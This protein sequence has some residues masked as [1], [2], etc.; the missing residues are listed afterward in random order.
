MGSAVTSLENRRKSCHSLQSTSNSYKV[1]PPTNDRRKSCPSLQ[2]TSNAY[3]VVPSKND[4]NPFHNLMAGR[5]PR[6]DASEQ[7]QNP[8]NFFGKSVVE[9][10]R[11]RRKSWADT[12]TTIQDFNHDDDAGKAIRT[13]QLRRGP[14]WCQTRPSRSLTNSPISQF[15]SLELTRFGVKEGG[16]RPRRRKSLNDLT[17]AVQPLS[18]NNPL[19]LAVGSSHSRSRS[20][21]QTPTDGVMVQPEG[22]TAA[23]FASQR[24][25]AP[26]PRARRKSWCVDTTYFDH[27]NLQSSVSGTSVVDAIQLVTRQLK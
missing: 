7:F 18:E 24:L 8:S 25:A 5:E 15:Q 4:K 22:R 16:Q 14:T 17:S 10:R 12:L 11:R 13:M 3:K 19:S 20:R 23:N 2:S 6:V 27:L 1:V 9:Y 21:S 26:V